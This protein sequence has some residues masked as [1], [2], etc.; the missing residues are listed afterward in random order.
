MPAMP[1]RTPAPPPA[2]SGSQR[3]MT[4]PCAV[5][6]FSGASLDPWSPPGGENALQ[7]LTGGGDGPEAPAIPIRV[8]RRVDRGHHSD[9]CRARCPEPAPCAG[10]VG[11]LK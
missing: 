9:G 11:D 5:V 6:A 4:A 10:T 3:I 7:P 8:D 1:P 2:A